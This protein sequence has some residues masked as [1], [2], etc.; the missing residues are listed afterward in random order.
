MT[1]RET[2]LATAR[3]WIDT[4]YR[5]RAR[6]QGVGCD[7]L[8]L[9]VE[10]YVAAGLLP[11][12]IEIPYYPPD[13]MFHSSDTRYVDTV[14]DYCDEVDTPQPGDLVMWKYGKTYSHAGIVSTW[15]RIVHAY[16]PYGA[17]IEMSV[18]DDSR[19]ANRPVRFFAPRGA[20]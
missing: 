19:L 18:N 3:A 10:A 14:L 1:P 11:A 6:R 16:A 9:I 17:V 15:P 4:P 13:M 20:A 7:C 12:D 2:A 8:M 5:H